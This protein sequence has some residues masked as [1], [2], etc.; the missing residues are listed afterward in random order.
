MESWA[1]VAG[2][3]ALITAI[4]AAVVAFRK[5]GPESSQIL[6]D[7][8]SDVV[9]IQREWITKA[10]ARA[11]AAEARAEAVEVKLVELQR[12]LTDMKSL[13]FEVAR[14]REQVSRRDQ[15]I[16]ALESENEQLRARV[17]H[18]EQNGAGS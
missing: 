8:A 18:L 12:Q 13:E 5:A 11:S 9:V 15:R 1:W 2:V 4:G 6:V 7:A 17:Q 14:M 16:E 10:E 3:A